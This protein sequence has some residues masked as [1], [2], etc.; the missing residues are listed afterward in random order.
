MVWLLPLQ[1]SARAEE[2]QEV[3]NVCLRTPRRELV[4]EAVDAVAQAHGVAEGTH[5]DRPLLLERDV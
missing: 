5:A 4:S 2:L 1:L 3:R